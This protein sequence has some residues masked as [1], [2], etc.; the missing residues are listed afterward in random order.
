MEALGYRKMTA[1]MFLLLIMV[2]CLPN[3]AS[4]S[5]LD[6]SL[7]VQ[8]LQNGRAD[9]EFGAALARVVGDLDIK[10]PLAATDRVPTSVKQKEEHRDLKKK[11]SALH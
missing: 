2:I 8:Q 6:L 3:Y 11:N 1:R 7:I 9:S 10:S 5:D 4:A